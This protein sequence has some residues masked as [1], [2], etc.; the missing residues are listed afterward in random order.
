MDKLIVNSTTKGQIIIKRIGDTGATEQTEILL[1][2]LHDQ[3]KNETSTE[4]VD[5]ASESEQEEAL[6]IS[7]DDWVLILAGTK[8]ESYEKK[9]THYWTR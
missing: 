9:R 7:D 3:N 4:D 5:E 8:V 2:T 1:N 6:K